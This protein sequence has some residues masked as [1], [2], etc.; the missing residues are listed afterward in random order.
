MGHW[1]VF[2]FP[3]PTIRDFMQ[4][5]F[6]TQLGEGLMFVEVGTGLCSD[7]TDY[8]ILTK[9]PSRLPYRKSKFI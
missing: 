7:F 3:I 4:H 2:H 8:Q 5:G 6:E 9:I 1:I